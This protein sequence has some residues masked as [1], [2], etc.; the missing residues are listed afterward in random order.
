MGKFLPWSSLLGQG[1]LIWKNNDNIGTIF[2][3]GL[4]NG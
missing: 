1:I 3:V 2:F 4:S